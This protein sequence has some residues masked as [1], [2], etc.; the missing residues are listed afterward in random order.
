MMKNQSNLGISFFASSIAILVGMLVA[1]SPAMAYV[2]LNG[3]YFSD[4]MTA[5][6][7]TTASRMFIEGALG[8]EIDKKGEYL[9]G[10]A[11]SM[12]TA[13]DGATATTSYSST[14]MGPRFLYMLDKNKNW[15]I[16]LGYYLVTTA[17]FNNG[18]TDETWKG[19]ALKADIGYSYSVSEK[20]KLGM[21]LNYG[22]ATYTEKFV[23]GVTYS[24]ISY[25]R[26]F[27][28]PSLYSIYLF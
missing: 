22:L 24:S 19:T 21:R 8:F 7:N 28:Y 26:S 20:F 10:W 11:Y 16:G 23:G 9:A 5:A 14:Q 27:M 15:S 18:T 2:E 17:K 13:S 12:F 4:A 3:F 1:S 6:T 25:T